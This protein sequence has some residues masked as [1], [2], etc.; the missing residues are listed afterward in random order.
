MKEL[1]AGKGQKGEREQLKE[2]CNSNSRKNSI[3]T[4]VK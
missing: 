1:K 2:K 3:M 4:Y